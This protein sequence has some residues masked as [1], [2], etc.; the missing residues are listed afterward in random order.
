MRDNTELA[1]LFVSVYV[2]NF[3]LMVNFF[4]RLRQAMQ[5]KSLLKISVRPKSRII[6]RNA[7]SGSE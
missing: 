7:R 1:L 3:F 6:N 2:I 5:R 4:C